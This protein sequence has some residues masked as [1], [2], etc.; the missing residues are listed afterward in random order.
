MYNVQCTS[1][2]RNL[3][4]CIFLSL[5]L[6]S[7]LDSIRIS[8]GSD[9]AKTPNTS[10]IL[11]SGFY[12]IQLIWGICPQF[13]CGCCSKKTAYAIL[14]VS[15]L[16]VWISYKDLKPKL[17]DCPTIPS[18]QNCPSGQDNQSNI[19]RPGWVGITCYMDNKICQRI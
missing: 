18:P 4:L 16:L 11:L 3:E 8:R 17:I 7:Q 13:F 9:S 5:I 1:W 6:L 19:Q 14:W 10:V 2:A 12:Q 15:Q